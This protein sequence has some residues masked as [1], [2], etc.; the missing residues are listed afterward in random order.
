[1]SLG[2]YVALIHVH[3]FAFCV[4]VLWCIFKNFKLSQ[5]CRVPAPEYPSAVPVDLPQKCFVVNFESS[6]VLV[7]L[8]NN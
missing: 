3:M 5:T 2:D 1:M 4:T 8:P 6:D 7:K